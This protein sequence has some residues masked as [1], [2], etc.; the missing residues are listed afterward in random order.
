MLDLYRHDEEHD[1]GTMNHTVAHRDHRVRLA[2]L[3]VE[4]TTVAGRRMPTVV[5][6]SRTRRRAATP[7]LASSTPVVSRPV[8]HSRSG[9]NHG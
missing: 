4:P 7:W 3:P 8:P 9:G 1:D 5:S 6:A 2:A